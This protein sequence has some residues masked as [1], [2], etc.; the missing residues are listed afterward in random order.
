MW[1]R[2]AWG[3]DG[4]TGCA[5]LGLWALDNRAAHHRAGRALA[6]LTRFVAGAD[7][8]RARWDRR[9]KNVFGHVWWCWALTLEHVATHVGTGG[10]WRDGGL[11]HILGPVDVGAVRFGPWLRMRLRVRSWTRWAPTLVRGL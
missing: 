7:T 3:L 4:R 10:G 1:L 9:F 2:A 6:N 8:G 5:R 11:E